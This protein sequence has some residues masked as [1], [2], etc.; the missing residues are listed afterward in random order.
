MEKFKIGDE[1]IVLAGSE[2]GKKA[3]ILKINK[4]TNRVLL[5]GLNKVKKAT[6]PTQENPNGG[7][8]EFE[9]AINLSNVSHYSAKSNS[10][11]RVGFVDQDG[12]MVRQL[13]KCSTII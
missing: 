6:K 10:A 12:K 7:F 11:S 1:V 9:K 5:E 3:K 2:K 8:V 13:K 4:K